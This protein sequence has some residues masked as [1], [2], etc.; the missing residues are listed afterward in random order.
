MGEFSMAG[1][2][3]IVVTADA[4]WKTGKTTFNVKVAE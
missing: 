4:Q 2:W 3:E 1:E